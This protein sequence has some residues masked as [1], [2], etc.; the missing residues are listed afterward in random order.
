M[1]NAAATGAQGCFATLRDASQ[2]Y[3]CC[4]LRMQAIRLLDCEVLVCRYARSCLFLLYCAAISGVHD[5]L[6]VQKL[7][8][9]SL[10][11]DLRSKRRSKRVPQDYS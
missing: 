3:A 4:T 8:Y 2:A 11:A 10:I 9:R 5:T 1:E 6:R 7:C